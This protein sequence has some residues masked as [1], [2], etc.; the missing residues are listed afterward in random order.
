MSKYA[1]S[2]GMLFL[3]LLLVECQE[4]KTDVH[5]F[6]VGMTE[7]AAHETVA[8]QGI[9]C[10]VQDGPQ[11]GCLLGDTRFTLL[12]TRN[13]APNRLRLLEYVFRSEAS[14]A[15]VEQK[16]AEDFGVRFPPL[17]GDY[18]EGFAT[19]PDGAELS[20]SGDPPPFVYRLN[21]FSKALLDEDNQA[22]AKKEAAKPVP[23]FR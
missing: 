8:S 16:I 11:W 3:F 10:A 1:R 21:I 23:S 2:V 19:L 4:R 22:G 6:Y 14:I 5:G 20:I 18:P 17:Q 7:Q 12:F 15:G 9:K 13:L